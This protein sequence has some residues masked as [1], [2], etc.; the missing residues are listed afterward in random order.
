MASSKKYALVKK[1]SLSPQEIADLKENFQKFDVNGDG[2]IDMSELAEVMKLI[3]ESYDPERL[4]KLI[5]TA[6]TDK[7]GKISFEEFIS[8]VEYHKHVTLLLISLLQSP[9][10]IVIF[11]VTPRAYL[12]MPLRKLPGAQFT[13]KVLD[14]RALYSS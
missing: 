5:E 10:H 13:R 12:L 1:Y 3:G 7:D 6:D 11:R 8:L 2:D 4:R 14:F 9:I